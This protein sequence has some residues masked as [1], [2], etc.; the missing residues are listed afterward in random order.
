MSWKISEQEIESTERLLLPEKAHF[1]EDAR[2]VIRCWESTDVLACPGSG[3]TTA[4]LAKLKIL[5][6]RMPFEDGSGICVFSHTNVAVDEI[7][8]RLPS[9]TDKLLNYPNYIGTI[10]SFVDKFITLPYLRNVTKHNIKL[11]DDIAYAKISKYKMERYG[12]YKK[13]SSFIYMKSNKVYGEN[14]KINYLKEVCLGK[15]DEIL[16]KGKKIA[17]AN[18][19]S[20]K[21]YKLLVN[22]LLN[23][24]GIITYKLAYLYAEKSLNSLSEDYLDLYSARFKYVFIDEYQDCDKKQIG[25]INRLFNPTKSMVMKIG[26]KDQAIYDSLDNNTNEIQWNTEES[27]L[28]MLGS[29][30]YSQEIANLINNL[31]TDNKKITT[32]MGETG[33]KTVLI[34]FDTDKIENVLETFIK[35]L[36]KINLSDQHG[37]YKAVGFIKK[38]STGKG[39]SIGSYWK[40]FDSSNNINREFTYWD[41]IEKIVYE[42]LIG[43]L[44]NVEKIVRQIICKIFHYFGIKNQK[45]N[46]DFT[47]NSLKKFLDENYREEYRDWIYEISRINKNETEEIDKIVE[48]ELRKIL[49]F[50]DSSKDYTEFERNKFFYGEKKIC[51]TIES[52]ARNIYIDS[53]TGRKIEFSTIHSVKG[54][55]HDATLYL[56]TSYQN[57]TDLN[58]ILSFFNT[59]TNF[60]EEIK[61]Y[62]RKL[63][64]VGMSRPRKLLC[65]AMQSKTY[66]KCKKEMPNYFDIVDIR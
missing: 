54:E 12:S 16:Y 5:A 22:D 51:K 17:D 10:Q 33:I 65:V 19:D 32:T 59:K 38:E 8:K 7:K 42:L 3:K 50:V 2:D 25:L 20:A 6:D 27:C 29:C 43:K 63:A 15:D 28:Q 4:L 60:K 21:Q 49:N 55:T 61:E 1:T 18:S 41:L 57:S 46:R 31:R 11:V 58:R 52:K 56:E 30:R 36:N 35:E 53:E 44:Y 23:N 48:E 62:S 9:Y 66:E 64:Y 47:M 39:L 40:E 13:F 14:K 24:E 26:D 45:T 34:V 37:V